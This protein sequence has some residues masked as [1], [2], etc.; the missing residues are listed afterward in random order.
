MQIGVAV[1]QRGQPIAGSQ[2]LESGTNVGKG[3]DRITR[4]KEHFEGPMGDL[5][6]ISAIARVARERCNPQVS[7]VVSLVRLLGRQLFPRG[8]HVRERNA[9]RNSRAVLLEPL[10]QEYLSTGNHRPDLPEGIIEVESDGADF[11]M[12]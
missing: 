4:G 2:P 3:F 12:H 8:T 7:E 10:D 11:G 6:V 9:L 1:R 5:L